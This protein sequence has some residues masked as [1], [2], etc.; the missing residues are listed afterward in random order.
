MKKSIRALL[1]C[2]VLL[3][4]SGCIVQSIK[5]FYLENAVTE[6]PEILGEWVRADE[7]K[8]EKTPK[9]W[10]FKEE[11]II[12]TGKNGIKGVLKATYFE[13]ADVI[14]LDTTISPP[15]DEG[16]NEWRQIHLAPVHLLCKVEIKKDQ[17]SL[18]PLDTDW[19]KKALDKQE[20]NLPPPARNQNDY[21]L[22]DASPQQWMALLKA[23]GKNPK[24]FSDGSAFKF[25]R[26][27]DFAK[28]EGK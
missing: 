14:F 20:I 11:E 27:A 2:T 5:P 26:P 25:V 1:L 28:K 22:F 16:L 19:M 7:I 6:V 24:L 12:T 21:L 8:D 10:A 9:P 18:I 4:F 15:E 3:F 17:L 23:H 13:V